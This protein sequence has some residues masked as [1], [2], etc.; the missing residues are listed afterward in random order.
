M[1]M[2]QRKSFVFNKLQ[3]RQYSVSR[4][5]KPMPHSTR[6]GVATLRWVAHPPL[7]VAAGDS[8]S[9]SGK[10][11]GASDEQR[12]RTGWVEASYAADYTTD[13]LGAVLSGLENWTHAYP[14]PKVSV[15]LR[16]SIAPCMPRLGVPYNWAGK[17]APVYQG[18]VSSINHAIIINNRAP[19]IR[20]I[21]QILN[22]SNNILNAATN[23]SI[24]APLLTPHG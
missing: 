7:R 22:T 6:Y 11:N 14:L 21:I 4:M 13:A 2:P 1:T 9:A 8:A 5:C 12:S 24:T 20:N 18:S 23:R 10:E 17:W 19:P 15:L 16:P 3:V